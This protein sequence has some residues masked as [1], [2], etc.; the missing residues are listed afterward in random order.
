MYICTRS[1]RRIARS[2]C[3]VVVAVVKVDAMK[4]GLGDIRLVLA[5][6]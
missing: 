1:R 3:D 2:D 4:V 5:L 6:R